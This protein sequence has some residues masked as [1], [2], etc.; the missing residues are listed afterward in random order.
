MAAHLDSSHDPAKGLRTFLDFAANTLLESDFRNGCP[1]AAVTLDVA[2]DRESVR[3]TCEQ[4][5]DT[6]L[7]VFTKYLANTGIS[8][9]R[10]ASL[11]T[12]CFAALEGGLILSRAQKSI[13]PLNAI[14]NELVQIIR[15]VTSPSKLSVTRMRPLTKK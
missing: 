3:D 6:L 5:F 10:V 7:T 13:A 8:E 4:C 12:L 2:C 15:A 9:K 14:A 11:A 1:I